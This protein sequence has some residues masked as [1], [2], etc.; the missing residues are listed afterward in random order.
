M[1]KSLLMV[2]IPVAVVG[3]GIAGYVGVRSMNGNTADPFANDLKAADAAG[4]QL[5]TAQTSAKYSL[6][7]IAP[8]SKPEPKTTIRKGAGPKAVRAKNPTVRAAAEN[9]V[10]DV[11]ENVPDQAVVTTA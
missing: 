6:S 11:E 4:I 1:R 10:A 2:G 7:E 3:L 5:A 9:S 8:D